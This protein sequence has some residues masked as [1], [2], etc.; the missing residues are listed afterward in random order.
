MQ[1]TDAAL[2]GDIG[3]IAMAAGQ[4]PDKTPESVQTDPVYPEQGG[5]NP[6]GGEVQPVA[7]RPEVTKA[8]VNLN[9]TNGQS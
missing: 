7:P 6:G 5:D 1:V 4:N 8:V 9:R 3:N 2:G